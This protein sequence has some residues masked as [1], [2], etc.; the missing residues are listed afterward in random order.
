MRV[1]VLGANGMLGSESIRVLSPG[2]EVFAAAR[3][4]AAM[5]AIGVDAERLGLAKERLFFGLDATSVRS[6]QSII[7]DVQ[8]EVVLNAVG[9]VKQRASARDAV[10]S[11]AV[12][13]LWPHMLAELCSSR[14]IRLVQVSTD[15][16]FS[17]RTGQYREDDFPDADDLYG[18]SKLLGEVVN[19]ENVITV[20]TSIVGWQFGQQNGLFGW[21]ASHRSEPLH[22]YS[23]AV[24]SGLTTR[25]FSETLRDFILPNPG[26]FGLWHISSSPI[27]KF[28]LLSKL[29][30]AMNWLVRIT[31]DASYQVDKSLDSSKFQKAT[32]W[33]P[34][35]WDDMLADL[36][37]EYGDYYA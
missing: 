30:T 12:N 10:Q 2:Y 22:G 14:G 13:S 36:V 19:L 23:R 28:A 7:D 17:G 25:V 4:R 26:L 29:S 15:C 16:V 32:G 24:F 37:P 27:D 31:P 11:I 34:D 21:F 8:P 5:D 3:S 18:R 20:R 35:S 9:V 33:A 6:V 1:L